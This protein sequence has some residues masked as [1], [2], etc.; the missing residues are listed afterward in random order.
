MNFSN[1][2]SSTLA[3]SV[4]LSISGKTKLGICET[5]D[6]IPQVNQQI[7]YQ[8]SLPANQSF[9][10]DQAI[11]HQLIGSK[12]VTKFAPKNSQGENINLQQLASSSGYDHYNWV[13]YVE[14]DPY[15]IND[16]AGQSL[17]T[18]YI[19]PPM[20]GYQYDA[21]DRLPFY[22]DMVNCDRCRQRHHFEHPENSE[23][24]E[25]TFQDAPADYRLQ[26]GE[27]IEFITHLVG[28][29]DYNQQQQQAEWEVLHTFRWKLTNV[30]P[31]YNQVSLV[32]T[33]VDLNKLYP[34]LIS[35]MQL[36]GGVLFPNVQ[37][38]MDN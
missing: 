12:I 13:S 26:P 10:Y 37:L 29:T 31:N 14:K 35:A 7:S 8:Q 2:I 15:G 11:N 33:D 18:P 23:Q 22:W 34:S 3:I 9:A 6:S 19:D 27:A 32:D 30:R 28:V 20:G 24:F 17:S 1:L 4:L 21:A 5:T 25:L 36:D 16:Q 38:S